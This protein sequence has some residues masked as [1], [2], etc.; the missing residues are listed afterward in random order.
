MQRQLHSHGHV[1]CIS[2]SRG[3]AHSR[4]PK[5]PSRNQSTVKEVQLSLRSAGY[6]AHGYKHLQQHRMWVMPPDVPAAVLRT[7]V[8]CLF[9]PTCPC[10]ALS[11]V[12]LPCLLW[13]CEQTPWQA[14]RA[15][16]AP[17][18]LPMTL[19]H[20]P[21]GQQVPTQPMVTLGSSW[22]SGCRWGAAYKTRPSQGSI[23]KEESMAPCTQAPH[24]LGCSSL[25]SLTAAGVACTAMGVWS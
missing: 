22:W 6:S 12:R 2:R 16:P 21:C 9:C 1:P 14:T 10:T 15:T 11:F 8:L 18:F 4:Q 13:H 5:R 24:P 20:G 23:G 25:C 19:T 7:C 17:G 3:S